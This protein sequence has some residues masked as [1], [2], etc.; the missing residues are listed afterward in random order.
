MNIETLIALLVITINPKQ[1]KKLST[2]DQNHSFSA[3]C[4]DSVT[5]Q[6]IIE[7]IIKRSCLIM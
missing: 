2:D 6:V 7:T 5:G 4:L 3:I 1:P